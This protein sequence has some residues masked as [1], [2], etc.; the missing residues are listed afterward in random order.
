[1]IVTSL[2]E[3]NNGIL[4]FSSQKGLRD[5]LTH[6]KKLIPILRFP[7]TNNT[8]R[9]VWD[10]CQ[11]KIIQYKISVG[12]LF[13]ATIVSILHSFVKDLKND[14]TIFIEKLSFA[15]KNA[16]IMTNS[17]QFVR[18]CKIEEKINEALT[19]V[20]LQGGSY[21]IIYGPKGIGK[22]E[23]VDHMAIGKKGVV[24]VQVS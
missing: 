12:L 3:K 21:T 23:L 14:A 2:S 4:S 6:S 8:L 19:N 10:K 1:M 17:T 15:I 11:K 24:R 22:T 20:F 7:E 13:V 18:R 5:S 16:E 9:D